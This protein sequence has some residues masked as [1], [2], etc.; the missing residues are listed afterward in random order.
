MAV[1]EFESD[2]QLQNLLDNLARE[3]V[4][5]NIHWKLRQ[6]LTE[7]LEPY[8]TEF[9]QTTAFWSLTLQAHMDAAIFRLIRIYDGNSQALS[10]RNLL[11]TIASNLS[12]FDD[13][14]FKERLKGNPFVESLTAKARKPDEEQL[15]TD[16]AY[17]GSGNK[18]VKKLTI[19]RNTLFAHRSAANVVE[20]V[21]IATAYPLS[22]TEVSTLLTDGMEILNRYS[23]LFGATTHST[24]IVGHD[25]FMYVLGCIRTDLQHRRQKFKKELARYGRGE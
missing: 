17:V 14:K 7:Q 23:S 8:A 6:D 11:E 21:D 13:E 1:I 5:A 16:I 3:L 12:I 22:E 19:W 15:C 10:L 18:A 2:E 4:D 24:Q 9:N 25:D 20:R